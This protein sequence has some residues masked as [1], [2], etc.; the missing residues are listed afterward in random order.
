M[1]I[2]ANVAVQDKRDSTIKHFDW[3][4]EKVLIRHH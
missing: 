4:N 3:L 2:L 1:R